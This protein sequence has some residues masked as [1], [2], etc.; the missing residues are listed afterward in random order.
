[1]SDC[2]IG[3]VGKDFVLVAADT[4]VSR[5]VLILKGGEDKMV[6]LDDHKI[7]ASAGPTGDRVNFCQFIQKNIQLN[8]F[9]NGYPMS[10]HAVAHYT[11]GELAKALRENPYQ[12]NLL[13]GGFDSNGASLYTMDYLGS[14]HKVNHASQ[15]YAGYFVGGIL[16]KKFRN[17]LNLEEA[18]NVLAECTAELRRRFVL[19]CP[20][21]I[22]RIVDRE[23]VRIVQIPNLA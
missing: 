16:D 23:G 13:I 7:L 18:L 2:L 21:W 6:Q 9:R 4:E 11:R 8:Y 15:G 12:V 14:L 22:C 5:S 19:K 1:M 3:I 10:C 17:D 20:D